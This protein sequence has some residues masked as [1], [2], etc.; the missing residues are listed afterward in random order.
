MLPL[1]FVYK[2]FNFQKLKRS[3]DLIFKM[4]RLTARQFSG[5]AVSICTSIYRVLSPC[6]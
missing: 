6:S 2:S 1:I 5:K 4:L 3:E